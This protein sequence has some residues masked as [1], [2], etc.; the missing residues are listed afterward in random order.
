MLFLKLRQMPRLDRFLIFLK[1]EPHFLTDTFLTS[2]AVF[3]IDGYVS[4]RVMQIFLGSSILASMLVRVVSVL[5]MRSVRS[6]LY[7]LTTNKSLPDTDI[8]A[9][10]IH[11]PELRT[12]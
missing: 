11:R 7:C 10:L 4:F 12:L 8:I 2:G 3:N 1:F 5:R 9:I 6:V